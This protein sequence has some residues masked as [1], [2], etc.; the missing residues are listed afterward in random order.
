MKDSVTVA[1]R[2]RKPACFSV[3]WCPEAQ[4]DTMGR[5]KS[6]LE[7]RRETLRSE[8]KINLPVLPDPAL[9]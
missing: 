3:G 1:F 9:P 8:I 6:A 7:F 4:F 5:S 2:K